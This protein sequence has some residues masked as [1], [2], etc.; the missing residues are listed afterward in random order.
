MQSLKQ[1]SLKE[2]GKQAADGQEPAEGSLL[3]CSRSFPAFK[4]THFPFL[5]HMEVFG[6]FFFVFKPCFFKQKFFGEAE[7]VAAMLFFL[8]LSLNLVNFHERFNLFF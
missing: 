2:W 6:A 4:V 3:A 1:G 7:L 5:L 8:S